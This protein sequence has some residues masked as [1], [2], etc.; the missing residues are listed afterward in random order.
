MNNPILPEFDIAYN[1][2]PQNIKE[3]LDNYEGEDDYNELS[4]LR[5]SLYELGYYMDFYLTGDITELRPLKEG[6]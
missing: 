3:L 4:K 6:E 5:D 2:A 1:N